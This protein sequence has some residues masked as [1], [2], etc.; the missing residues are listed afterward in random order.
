MRQLPLERHGWKYMRL[1]LESLKC[2]NDSDST[3]LISTHHTREYPND[4]IW[5]ENGRKMVSKI[6]DFG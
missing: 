2:Q 4:A 1:G 3:D 5:D 6:Y